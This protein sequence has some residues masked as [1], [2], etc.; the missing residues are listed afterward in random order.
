MC[1]IPEEFCKVMKDFIADMM[2]TFPEMTRD[3]HPGMK[4]ILLGK[5]DTAHIEELFAYCQKIYPERFFDFLYQND[6]LFTDTSKNTMFLPNIEFKEV[7]K[8]NITDKTRLIIWKYLQLVLFAVVN[9][10]K[11]G[12]TFGDAAD[13]FEA[14]NEEE[15]KQK[16][17]ETMEQMSSIF[18]MSGSPFETSADISGIN[19]EELPDPEELHQHISGL[20]GGK[21]GRLAAKITEETMHEFEDISGVE[22]VEDIFNVLFKN[23]GRLIKMIK[24]IGGNLDEKLKSGEIK[25]SELLKEASELMEKLHKMPGIKNMQQMLGQMGMSLPKGGK[26]NMG[27]FKGQIKKNIRSAKMKERLQ[28]KL[29]KRQTV[30]KEHHTVSKEH[31]TVS[32]EEQ[33]RIL[34]Q[35]I[36]TLRATNNQVEQHGQSPRGLTARG[37]I[38]AS[39]DCISAPPDEV[40]QSKKQR[41]KK[42]RKRKNKK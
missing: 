11:D 39:D 21:L 13:L 34:Q 2:H 38:A 10:Q 15:L 8:Q 29:Q 19:L 30:S 6:E 33:I 17:E 25:E 27:A 3:L 5:K 31:H 35:Q 14:I 28:A 9:N 16:L 40:S 36:T 4:D 22:S 41:R 23:P 37:I 7:W 32:K 12:S 20:L 24:R 42:R 18:D 26:V 1:T